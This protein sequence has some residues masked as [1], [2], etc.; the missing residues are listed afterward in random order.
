MFLDIR[1]SGGE[2]L[3]NYNDQI[4]N[5]QFYEVFTVTGRV[6]FVTACISSQVYQFFTG[7]HVLLG[8]EERQ[9]IGRIWKKLFSFFSELKSPENIAS[10]MVS[11]NKMKVVWDAVS[12]ATSYNLTVLPCCHMSVD[13]C[14]AALSY[15]IMCFLATWIRFRKGI[16]II[17]VRMLWVPLLCFNRMTY[18]K[19]QVVVTSVFTNWFQIKT[20]HWVVLLA[21]GPPG[22]YGIYYWN[23]CFKRTW[24]DGSGSVLSKN[25]FVLEWPN[26]CPRVDHG[27]RHGFRSTRW[28][29]V[30]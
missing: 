27:F 15:R 29:Q 9:K 16:S 26:Y 4:D 30:T 5:Y 1:C 23:I 2:T 20:D 19:Q 18:P 7:S 17:F 28:N 22:R 8:E 12:G 24:N 11:S 6:I 13:V 3:R 14:F 10:I 25:R 21:K